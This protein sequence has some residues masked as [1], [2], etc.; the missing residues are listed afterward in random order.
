MAFALQNVKAFGKLQVAIDPVHAADVITEIRRRGLVDTN[1]KDVI[2]DVA[3]NVMLS[4][5]WKGGTRVEWNDC[6][7]RHGQHWPPR[8][9]K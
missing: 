9:Q 2:N 1:D 8:L 4:M 6:D 5:K 7:L 3:T